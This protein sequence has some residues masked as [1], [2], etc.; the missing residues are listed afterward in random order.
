[1][2]ALYD[3]LSKNWIED[4]EVRKI[5]MRMRDILQN[6]VQKQEQ[7]LSDTLHEIE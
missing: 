1:V 5:V 3:E 6:E 4:Y 2:Q 7:F